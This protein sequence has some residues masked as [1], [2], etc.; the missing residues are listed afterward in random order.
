MQYAEAATFQAQLAIRKRVS[1]E[2]TRAPKSVGALK[3]CSNWIPSTCWRADGR[4]TSPIERQGE[5]ATE[6]KRIRQSF[7]LPDRSESEYRPWQKHAPSPSPR[8]K[9]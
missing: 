5:I 2:T 8:R 6:Q 3:H 4:R 1:R 9:A 7:A